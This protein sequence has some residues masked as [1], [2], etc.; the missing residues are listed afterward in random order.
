M[1]FPRVSS[2][3]LQETGYLCENCNAPKHGAWLYRVEDDEM[4][5]NL[6]LKCV[7]ELGVEDQLSVQ[8]RIS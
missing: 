7:R 1:G 3:T 8:S 5:A 2:Y 6:C 4:F